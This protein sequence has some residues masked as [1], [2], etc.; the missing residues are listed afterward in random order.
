VARGTLLAT[1]LHIPRPRPGFVRR[2]RLLQQLNEGAARELTLVCAPAGFGKTSLLA[3][4][5]RRSQ[6]P[7]AWLSLDQ[8]D[9]DP[10]R[11]W[12]YASAALDPVCEGIAEA[13]AA[14][15]RGPPPP[16]EAVVTVVV[17]ELA[18]RAD[19]LALV[20]DDLHLI[21]AGPVHD[22]IA[23]L[24]DRLPGRLG[25]VLASRAD[26]PLQLALLRAR[27]QMVEL[28]AADLRFTSEEA[29][30]LLGEAIGLELPEASLATL[31]S[32]TEGWAAW[33]QLA[34]LSL[35]GHEDPEQYP[36]SDC[37][38]F[39]TG[40]PGWRQSSH[41][42]CWLRQASSA[43]GGHAVCAGRP[44]TLPPWSLA[45]CPHIRCSG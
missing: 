25:L 20:L 24:L 8:G 17:N 22:G 4:W 39:R 38:T 3:D 1:K 35:R 40:S 6:Q 33:S 28:R 44:L 31:A 9:N 11:F 43:A 2:K 29:A 37:V 21:E 26:P 5:A 16:L 45:P 32:R 23:L 7:V 34:A 14:L 18:A 36:G 19:R 41:S 10:T 15:L 12:R 30:A 27:S 42:S 13:V